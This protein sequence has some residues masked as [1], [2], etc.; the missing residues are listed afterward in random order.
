M[1]K[2]DGAKEFIKSADSI[3]QD[4]LTRININ[5]F[6]LYDEDELKRKINQYS[7]LYA[8]ICEYYLKALILPN[9][10]NANYESN[11]IDEMNYLANNRNGLKKFN[12]IFKKIINS[13]E[14]D[15]NI[16]RH[17]E[18][19]LLNNLPQIEYERNNIIKKMCVDEGIADVTEYKNLKLILNEN[20]H[21]DINELIDIISGNNG[22]ISNNSNAYPESRYAMISNYVADLKFL[23]VFCDAIRDSLQL[24]FKNCLRVNGCNR[25]IFPD[26]GTNIEITFGTNNTQKMFFDENEQLWITNNNGE[27]I[28]V[29]GYVWNYDMLSSKETIINKV[30]F[31]ENGKHKILVYDKKSEKYVFVKEKNRLLESDVQFTDNHNIRK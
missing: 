20:S 3:Y 1:N 18:N 29:I 26:S 14:F 30:S 22:F 17:I 5:S 23:S 13:D 21:K 7:M 2:I 11:S 6:E 27:K 8:Q 24:K 4:F 25:F 31:M 15:E 12:H 16:K 19:Y 28:D 9:L 10:E